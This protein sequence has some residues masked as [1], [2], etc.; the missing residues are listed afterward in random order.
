MEDFIHFCHIS[1]QIE[2]NNALLEL[3]HLYLRK[4]TRPGKARKGQERPEKARKGQKKPKKAEK[5]QKKA[6]KRPE[7]ARKGQK[8]RS[9]RSD[10]VRHG[11]T[12]SDTVR[13]FSF[14]DIL[15]VLTTKPLLGTARF[16]LVQKVNF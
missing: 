14:Q 13:K 8:R 16:A 3:K 7:K 12:R 15:T 5:G 2:K 9:D 10:T 4:Q 11:Q 6:R 1:Y